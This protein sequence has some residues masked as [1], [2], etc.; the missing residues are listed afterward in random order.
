LPSDG[1]GYTATASVEYYERP[2][3]A[4]EIDLKLS[5]SFGDWYY[6]NWQWWDDILKPV[7]GVEQVQL[8]AEYF[9]EL[10]PVCQ[11]LWDGHD[12]LLEAWEKAPF[13]R[14]EVDFFELFYAI[15]Q[16]PSAAGTSQRGIKVSD[17]DGLAEEDYEPEGPV[18]RS[19]R[20]TRRTDNRRLE[21]EEEERESV[22]RYSRQ[23]KRQLDVDDEDDDVDVE[24]EEE[25]APAAKSKKDVR[26]AA[27]DKMR[28]QNTAVNSRSAATRQRTASF[29]THADE[30][31]D[32]DYDPEEDAAA[33]F[34]E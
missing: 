31:E 16:P 15:N 19:S 30:F 33:T 28:R 34:G 21:E 29:E 27:V 32:S 10:G 2:G 11:Q 1:F 7:T 26:A 14:K 18:T 13:V 8:L 22:A 23:R 4:D 20:S 17:S 3:R 5:Q 9:P 24:I 25:S 12:K 6:E